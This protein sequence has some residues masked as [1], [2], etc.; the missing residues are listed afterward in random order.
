MV[1]FGWTDGTQS[2]H[3]PEFGHTDCGAQNVIKNKDPI[4]CRQCNHRIMYKMRTKR[5]KEQQQLPLGVLGRVSCSL[6]LLS[7]LLISYAFR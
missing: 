7:C 1:V 4:R 5:G 3:A 6:R 2:P